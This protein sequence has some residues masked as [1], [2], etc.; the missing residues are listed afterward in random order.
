[1]QMA[2]FMLGES[3][4]GNRKWELRFAVLSSSWFISTQNA[5]ITHGDDGDRVADE[6]RKAGESVFHPNNETF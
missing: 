2:M 3:S 1:M 4:D 6:R 5:G